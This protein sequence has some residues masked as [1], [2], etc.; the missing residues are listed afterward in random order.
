[1][2]RVVGA[3][4]AMAALAGAAASQRGVEESR[5]GEARVAA[6]RAATEARQRAAEGLRGY[7]RGLEARAVTAAALPQLRAQLQLL[8]GERLEGQLANTIRDSLSG[9]PEWEPFRREFKVYGISAEGDKLGLVQGMAG[10]DLHSDELVREARSN[11]MSTMLVSGASGAYGAAAARVA[12]P[13]LQNP[14]VIV[15]AK[16]VDEA[17]LREVADRAGGAILLT[18]GKKALAQQGPR[19]ELERLG[20]AV[21]HEADGASF[22]GS[23]GSWAAGVSPVVPGM[24]FWIYAG[25]QSTAREAERAATT[26]KA[27]IWSAS[28]LIGILSLFFG[29]RRSTAPAAAP[30]PAVTASPAA[31]PGRETVPS[32]RQIS[33]TDATIPAPEAER[34]S[35]AARAAYGETQIA[36]G[37][38]PSR[39]FGRYSLIDR[40]GE[41]GMAQVYTAVIF[42]A[43]GFRRKFVVKRLRPE[44]VSDPAVVAQFIDEANMASSLVHSNI[45]PVLDFGKVGD[46][47][48]LATEYILGRDLGRV[49]R[50]AQEKGA[51]GLPVQPVLF[52]ALETLKAL[53]YAHTRTGEGGKH[54]A[55][56]HR[57]VSP[58]NILVSARGEVKLFDFGIVK[59]EGRVTRTQHGVV[60]GNVS[61]MSP[62][63]ARG[64]DVDARADLFSLGLV[65]Y[66]CLSGDVLYQGN[67]SYELLLKAATGP[68]AEELARVQALPGPAGALVARAL[69]VDPAGRFQSAAEF[70]AAV[71]PHVGHGARELADLMVRLHG[72]EFRKEEQRFSGT[73]PAQPGLPGDAGA[74]AKIR[75]S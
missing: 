62:E 38:A 36:S 43:E 14:A 67:T 2:R 27:V 40:L 16:P 74:Q 21:G 7:L 45:I 56:V 19:A 66:Y 4:I 17:A 75:Q 72:E 50:T 49:T 5:S 8:R 13:G 9:E 33:G 57:D 51:R 58:G 65:M 35:L 11:G 70:A 37:G 42:G 41:G 71:A 48:F 10:A 20:Q 44:L 28:A 68:T 63:Q 6:E 22:V 1:M 29:W 64:L 73:L 18:D 54:L 30:A 3:L 32:A 52:A 55:I 24:W 59:A 39:Q 34:P 69:S 60:K 46:E 31:A 23:D 15:L 53:E 26:T 25:S 12:V 47:Y 61:F